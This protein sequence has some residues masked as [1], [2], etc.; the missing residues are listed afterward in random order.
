VRLFS[1][2][3]H[4]VEG[5]RVAKAADDTRTARRQAA[6]RTGSPAVAALTRCTQNC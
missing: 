1:E 6:G 2:E 4:N 5:C 3:D